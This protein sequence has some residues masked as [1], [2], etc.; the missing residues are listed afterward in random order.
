VPVA[1][2]EDPVA[3]EEKHPVNLLT[4]KAPPLSAENRALWEGFAEC[5]AGT[6]ERF[7]AVS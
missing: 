6:R 7:D 3:L 2:G 5:R 4:G 1:L